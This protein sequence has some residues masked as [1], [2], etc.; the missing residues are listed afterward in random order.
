MEKVTFQSKG[1]TLVGNLYK[2]ANFDETKKYPALIVD[3]SWTTVKEQMQGLYADKLAEKGFVTLTFDHKHFGESEGQPREY[4]NPKEKVQDIKDAVTFLQSFPFVISEKISGFGICASGAYMIQAASEDSRITSVATVA[5]WLMT[6]ETAKLFYGGDDG[7]NQRVGKSKEAL[8]V[9]AASGKAEYVPAYDPNNMEAAMFFPVDYYAKVERGAVPSWRNN[10]AVM[11]WE[12]WLTYDGVASS[13]RLTTPVIM[14]ASEKQFL[15]EGT[16]EA[17][18]NL[19][20]ENKNIK[21]LNHY[22]H[23]DFYDNQEAI[24]T[25]T[26]FIA[27]FL[28]TKN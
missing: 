7:I 14:I 22:E 12:Q 19:S 13:T 18:N 27:E 17:F 16:K 20:N 10:F 26:A 11:S 28:K 6:P 1:L 2:P 25:S 21:W 5:A 9:F 15:P 24:Q 3:G 8:S 23:T 4:E